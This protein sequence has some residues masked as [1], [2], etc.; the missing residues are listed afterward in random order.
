MGLL[1]QEFSGVF[2]TDAVY[3][4][5]ESLPELL[6]KR[7]TDE[8]ICF[9]AQIVLHQNQDCWKCLSREKTRRR[10]CS[11]NN[12][13]SVRCVHMMCSVWCLPGI[14]VL[15]PLCMP[16]FSVIKDQMVLMFSCYCQT[17]RV[18]VEATN[19]GLHCATL[20]GFS[21]QSFQRLAVPSE[22]VTLQKEKNRKTVVSI[23]LFSNK[24]DLCQ[25]CHFYLSD[26]KLSPPN[27][28]YHSWITLLLRYCLI[29]AESTLCGHITFEKATLSSNLTV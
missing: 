21:L 18:K 17:H 3:V 8:T 25:H 22:R 11:S 10:L 24:R 13:E 29:E 1:I 15:L 7:K 20:K 14:V 26:D 28:T 9:F 27:C 16:V 5:G 12:C 19:Y 2:N 23:G 6:R 4:C